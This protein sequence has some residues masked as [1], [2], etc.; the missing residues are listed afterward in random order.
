MGAAPAFAAEVATS[1]RTAPTH[2]IDLEIMCV[3]P[4]PVSS[5]QNSRSRQYSG[6]LRPAKPPPVDARACGHRPSAV[7]SWV[8]T[9][10]F[11]AG[12]A[13]FFSG[14]HAGQ[15]AGRVVACSTMFGMKSRITADSSRLIVSIEAWAIMAGQSDFVVVTTIARTSPTTPVWIMP[16]SP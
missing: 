6:S 16:A 4:L 13:A 11:V 5:F 14:G 12:S 8:G 9:P 7:S 10:E 2:S 15:P 3:S 1:V